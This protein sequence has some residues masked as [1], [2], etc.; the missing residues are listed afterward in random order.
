[1]LL[2]ALRLGWLEQ[3]SLLGELRESREALFATVSNYGRA[4]RKRGVPPEQMLIELKQLVR[5]TAI[6]R[7]PY[8]QGL[9]DKVVSWGIEAYYEDARR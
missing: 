8:P 2:D 3:A 4:L 9:M 7:A 6:K 5:D 1:M